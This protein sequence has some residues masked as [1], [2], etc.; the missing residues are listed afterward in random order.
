MTPWIER[1][2][3]SVEAVQNQ[4]VVKVLNR[5]T[6]EGSLF[7]DLRARRPVESR[8]REVA[9]D[10]GRGTDPFCKP[11]AGTPADTFG[12]VRGAHS[13][14]ASNVAKYDGLHSVVIFEEHDPHGW[15]EPQVM[16][17]FQ[18]AMRWLEEAHRAEPEAVYPYVMWNCLPRAGASIVHAHMQATLGEDLA[19]AR[20]ESWRRAMVMYRDEQDR[21]YF[22]DL[23][24]AHRLLGLGFERAG[25]RLVAHLTP[26]KEKEVL[27]IAPKA[28]SDLFSAVYRVLQLYLDALGVRAFNL[29]V[30]M[31]PLAP[32][33]ESWDGFPVVVRLVDRGDP[34]SGTSDIGT[35]ELFAQPVVSFDPWRL[36]ESL[37]S[38]L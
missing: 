9:V 28:D 6:L 38:L 22:E 19:Y 35:M 32:V 11:L 13:L 4:T 16:D 7:N 20:I 12:R 1:S 33:A 15:G 21:D 34:G 37:T 23:Y 10:T 30:Y 8:L 25:M 2:F 17:A 14:T 18:T 24:D 31:P 29:A 3:G 27:L 5:W 36:A 26:L